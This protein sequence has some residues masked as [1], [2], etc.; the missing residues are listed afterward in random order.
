MT[1]LLAKSFF[2]LPRLFWA[3]LGALAV[4]AALVW[5][6]HALYQDIKQSGRDEVQAQWE[7]EKAGRA[8]ASAELSAAL[9]Q[10]FSG[11]DSS[12]QGAIKTISY[13]GRDITIRVKKELDN[14]P[15]YTSDV[16]SITPGV[17]EQINAARSLSNPAAASGVRD[18]GVPTSG[19]AVR[20][21]IRRADS[22]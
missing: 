22:R 13:K 10:A 15:R 18:G 19:A 20:L 11:L 14:D 1:W 12:L 16:C 17:F 6:A 2:G 5:G 21:D 7:A 3:G 9:T 4:L 8:L